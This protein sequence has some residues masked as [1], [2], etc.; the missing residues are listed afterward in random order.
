MPR[1]R[2]YHHFI[3]HHIK[4]TT[5]LTD[6]VNGS[7]RLVNGSTPDEGR[8]EVCINGEWGTACDQYWD[9]RETKVVCRQL[10]Y[11]SGGI[12]NYL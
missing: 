12:N 4:S 8:V 3:K 1:K 9:R 7:V 2:L 10:G 6:C 5:V 11:G